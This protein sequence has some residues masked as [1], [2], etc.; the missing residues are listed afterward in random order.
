MKSILSISFL[1]RLIVAII[2]LQTLYFKFSAAPE[3]VFIF[4]AIG[5]EPWGR[6][7]SGIIELMASILI[8]LPRTIWL[9]AFMALGTMTGALFFHLTILGIN[10]EGDDGLLFIMACVVFIAS[11]I[12]L[13]KERKSIPIIGTKY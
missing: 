10:V 6:I 5:M 8:L 9:G 4:S 1:L 11:L 3:S 7:G 13:W 2:F 12:T